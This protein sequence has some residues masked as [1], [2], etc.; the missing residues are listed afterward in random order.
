MLCI[1]YIGLRLYMAGIYYSNIHFC[2]LFSDSTQMV[3]LIPENN[4][5]PSNVDDLLENIRIDILPGFIDKE[6]D[7]ITEEH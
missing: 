6:G 7:E 1:L 4:K 5:V 3:Y 2:W